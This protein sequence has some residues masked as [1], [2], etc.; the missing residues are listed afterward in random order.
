MKVVT[1]QPSP[2]TDQILEDGTELTQLPYPLHVEED[3]SIQR[4]DFWAGKPLRVIGFANDL[5]R[6]SI[7]LWWDDA[8]KNPQQVV[9]K[10]IVT[11]D[12]DGTWSSWSSAVSD[13]EVHEW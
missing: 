7:D 2:I 13:V 12:K 4:Q 5:A 8:V 3:G 11:V 9:G 6:H 1:L 10:Y